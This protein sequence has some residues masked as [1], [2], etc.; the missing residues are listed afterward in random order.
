MII[1]IQEGILFAAL[2]MEAFK[3]L[4]VN[5]DIPSGFRLAQYEDIVNLELLRSAL[6]SDKDLYI[7]RLQDG[8][9]AGPGYGYEIKQ[10][11]PDKRLEYKLLIR[12]LHSGG[13]YRQ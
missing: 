9:V 13:E 8:Q 11:Q 1:Y 4:H 12:T 7:C 3:V 10:Q 5:D 2:E 6:G